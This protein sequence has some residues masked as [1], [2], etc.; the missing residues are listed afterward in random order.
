MNSPSPGFWV[1]LV[2]VSPHRGNVTPA[3]VALRRV[4]AQPR[5]A[6]AYVREGGAPVAGLCEGVSLGRFEDQGELPGEAWIVPRHSGFDGKT[7]RGRSADLALALTS[8]SKYEDAAPRR[9]VIATGRLFGRAEPIPP[10]RGS[11]EERLLLA[12]SDAVL[13]VDHLDAKLTT[14]LQLVCDRGWNA[15]DVAILYPASQAASESGPGAL[16]AELLERWQ[17]RFGVALDALLPVG[18]LT[19]AADRVLDKPPGLRFGSSRIETL[20]KRVYA[21][22]YVQLR[23]VELLAACKELYAATDQLGES[24]ALRLVARFHA[25]SSA[26]FACSKLLSYPTTQPCLW[27]DSA[28]TEA[29]ALKSH[30]DAEIDRLLRETRPLPDGLRELYAA[31]RNYEA[32]ASFR[33]L[34]FE[35][36]VELASEGLSVDGL[37][38]EHQCEYRKLLGTRG[39]FS[40]RVGLRALAEGH[41]GKVRR[42]LDAATRDI[43]RALEAAESLDVPE[44]NDR[45]RARVYHANLLLARWVAGL[46]DSNAPERV[47]AMLAEVLRSYAP[48]AHAEGEPPTQDPAWALHQLYTCWGL[49][50]RWDEILKHWGHVA[51]RPAATDLPGDSRTLAQAV[52]TAEVR[53]LPAA[54]PMAALLLEATLR[55][56][57]TSLDERVATAILAPVQGE[58]VPLERL[59]RWW[60]AVDAPDSWALDA[61]RPWVEDWRLSRRQVL[62]PPD[63]HGVPFVQYQLD[64]LRDEPGLAPAGGARS[65]LLIWLGIPAWPSG[66]P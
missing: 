1:P 47:A 37:R 55:C 65:R 7:L 52:L 46:E 56:G 20:R 6:A 27:N 5:P 36:G 62:L 60:P 54:E 40:W 21:L 58:G 39:Q 17:A 33:T 41:S 11:L 50:G 25:V 26:S 12:N 9:L 10:P 29:R 32:T 66:G 22:R 57:E 14:C 4:V 45:S 31:H 16:P 61:I 8:L 53:R 34:D 42:R 23:A 49:A 63:A 59:V 51:E 48:G 3:V 18:T 28:P 43:S 15:R 38:K 24:S 2:L 30:L 19:E 64:A 35:E 13:P 44:R